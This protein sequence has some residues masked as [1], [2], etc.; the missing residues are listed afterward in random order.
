M[1]TFVIYVSSIFYALVLTLAILIIQQLSNPHTRFFSP[2]VCNCMS[3]NAHNHICNQHFSFWDPMT[4]SLQIF[5]WWLEH[6]SYSRGT[7]IPLRLGWGLL[8]SSKR[9]TLGHKC[10]LQFICFI[11]DPAGAGLLQFSALVVIKPVRFSCII[12]Y[13]GSRK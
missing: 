10:F 9:R 13:C 6:A 1:G 3:E 2:P 7:E 11:H 4:S 8:R 5:I 12:L